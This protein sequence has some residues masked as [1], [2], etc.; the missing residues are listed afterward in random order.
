MIKR[1][2]I[3]IL[4]NA[5]LFQVGW[6]VCIFLGDLWAVA[7]TV[8]A[9]AFHFYF[10]RFLL[11]LNGQNSYRINV[12]T[13]VIAVVIAIILGLMHDGILLHTHQVQFGE[14]VNYLPFWLICLWVLLG[15][16]LNHSIRWIYHR[17]MW[18][19]LFGAF[20]APLS[21]LAGVNLSEAEW[22]KPLTQA[23]PLIAAMWLIVLPLHR[24]LSVRTL[25]YVKSKK[26]I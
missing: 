12:I 19:A 18:S 1:E 15:L 11:D 26:A 24:F 4:A 17:P 9:L 23:L 20:F 10:I 7:F 5:I 25:S 13:D 6:L 22:S 3:Y 8:A 14:G 21:Y 2:S 16:T